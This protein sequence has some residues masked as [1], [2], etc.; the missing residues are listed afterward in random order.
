MNTLRY[1]VNH[2]EQS[3]CSRNKSA[4]LKVRVSQLI[5]LTNDGEVS[6]LY[7]RGF[8]LPCGTWECT[9]VKQIQK[10]NVRNLSRE[11]K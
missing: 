9:D 11:K 10:R 6:P 8:F 3:Q 5:P 4:R 1:F 7:R 2:R